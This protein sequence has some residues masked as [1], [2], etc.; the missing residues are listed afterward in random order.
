MKKLMPMMILLAA[1]VVAGCDTTE[2]KTIQINLGGS[3]AAPADVTTVH[4][5][6]FSSIMTTIGPIV[7][8]GSANVTGG[9]TQSAVSLVVP[10]G[11]D[12]YVLVIAPSVA[13]DYQ[14]YTGEGVYLKD[15][16]DNVVAISI[17][18]P[19]NMPGS[20]TNMS[21]RFSPMAVPGANFSDTGFT[22]N[23]GNVGPESIQLNPYLQL[24]LEESSDGGTSYQIMKIL[25]GTEVIGISTGPDIPGVSPVSGNWYRA[26]LYMPAMGIYLY[27]WDSYD[28]SP[29]ID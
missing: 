6:V 1:V 8:V 27:T 11:I 21:L 24:H 28:P 22:M 23:L 16:P 2:T 4:V 14:F 12:L 29:P 17:Q 20:T 26:R 13:Y 15:S 10:A 5:A 7:A 9:T 25:S 19:S 18:Q 3:R